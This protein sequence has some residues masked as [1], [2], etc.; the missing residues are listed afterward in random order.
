MKRV[1]TLLLSASLV[2]AG[3]SAWAASDPKSG[4]KVTANVASVYPPN[5]PLDLGLNKLKEILAEHTGGR[6]DSQS[7]RGGATR[8]ETQTFEMRSQGSV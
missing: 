6:S 5:S 7:Q 4:K 2:A 3:G 8:A 1:V